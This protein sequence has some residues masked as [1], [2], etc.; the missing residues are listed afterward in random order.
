MRTSPAHRALSQE[1]RHARRAMARAVRR[2]HSGR[3]AR[4]NLA[5]G[6]V[7]RVHRGTGQSAVCQALEMARVLR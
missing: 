6:L 3:V 5:L 7:S 1:V 2:G 4:L